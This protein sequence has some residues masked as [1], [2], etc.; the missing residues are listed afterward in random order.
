MLSPLTL[1]FSS[2]T[3]GLRL[4]W[5]LPFCRFQPFCIPP[6]H[7]ASSAAT[8][9]PVQRHARLHGDQADMLCGAA[10]GGHR[11]AWQE[12]STVACQVVGWEEKLVHA[13]APAAGAGCST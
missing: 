7:A 12:E 5:V 1:A 11:P 8:V 2:A 3:E 13:A 9:C 6:C 4:M 10:E